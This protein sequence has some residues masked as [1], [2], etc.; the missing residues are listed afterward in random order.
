MFDMCNCLCTCMLERI[1]DL[2]VLTRV[3]MS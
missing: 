2:C 1:R 3:S